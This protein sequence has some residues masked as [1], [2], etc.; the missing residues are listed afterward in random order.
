LRRAVA[1]R[2]RRL[3]PLVVIL[4][5]LTFDKVMAQADM[6]VDEGL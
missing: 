1:E 2:D 4:R 5:H 3:H 6:P